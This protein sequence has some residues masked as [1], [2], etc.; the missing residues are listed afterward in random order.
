MPDDDG[1]L[2]AWSRTDGIDTVFTCV[3][4]SDRPYPSGSL[5]GA[6]ILVSTDSSLDGSVVGGELPARAAFVARRGGTM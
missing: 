4:P 1:G 3:N 2:L 5:A 6:T